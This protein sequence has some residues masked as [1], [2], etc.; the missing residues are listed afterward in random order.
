M[1]NRI[2]YWFHRLSSKPEQRGEYSAGYWQERVRRETFLLSGGAKGKILDI[3]CGEGL[4]LL[5]LAKQNP[6]AEFWGI[7][8]NPLRLEEIGQKCREENLKNINLS[9]QD[10]ASLNF[11]D[12][13]FD[14]V[15]C[16]NVFMNMESLKEV[17]RTLEQMKRVCKKSGKIIFDFRNGNNPLFLIKYGLARYYDRTVRNLPLNAYTQKQIE[18]VLEELALEITDKKFIDSHI[19]WLAPVIVIEAKRR[20]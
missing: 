20:C 11:G 8:N 17:K 13:Y 6:E 15:I 14:S 10:S 1:F 4:F 5:K 3:G 18:S 7:D 2:Y 19:K 12:E 9:L 16:I